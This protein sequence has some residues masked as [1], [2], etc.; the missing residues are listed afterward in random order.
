MSE[1]IIPEVNVEANVPS[2][3]PEPAE[4][5]PVV[6]AAAVN[7]QE[8]GIPELV[9][10]FE[11][12]AKSEDRMQR[13]KEADAIKSAFYKKLIKA[14]SEAGIDPESAEENPFT[15]IEEAFK[16]YY[17]AFKK[18]KAEY[19]KA[20]E[21]ER[22]RNLALKQAVIEDLKQL[23]EK[24][25]D[26]KVTFPEFRSIQDRWKAVGPVPVQNFRNLNETYQL[27]VEQF[28][29]M[30]NIN[31]ELRDLDFKK[32]LEAKTAFCEEAEALAQR[33]DVVEAFRE[34]QKLH[35]QW[36]DYGPVEKQYRESIWE[37]FKAATAVINRNYQAHFEGLKEQQEANL[38][39]KTALCEKAEAIAAAE[40]ANANEWNAATKTLEEIQKEW[41]GIGF[42]SKKDNQKIYDRF[43]AACDAFFARKKEF[44]AGF[45]E[46]INENLARK[47]AICEQAEALKDSTDWKATADTLIDLQKQWKEI[48]AVPR[49]KSDALWKRFRAACDSFFE[50]RDKQP[51]DAND[52]YGN[53]KAKQRLIAEIN[54][55]E[56][57]GDAEADAEAGSKFSES[58]QAI[59]FVPFK[60]KDRI[61]QAYREAMAKFNA[62]R[63]ASRRQRPERTPMT[64]KE[65]LVKK[66]N[67][68]EQDIVTYENNLGFFARSKNA[69]PLIR[70]MEERIAKAKEELR[71]LEA[72]IR[73]ME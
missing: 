11:Q 24:Q 72:E 34:L 61:A 62:G 33:S 19:N 40:M 9:A 57:S 41:R 23:L 46:S 56:L 31:R 22:E 25:E 43:R 8:M 17:N 47:L 32:N 73:S 66:Y 42:A 7:Y 5:A 15:G 35:E 58:W 49:Q 70:Q 52:Y 68:L 45:K 64:E 37:R 59:G 2:D 13:A 60:E 50:A 48:G 20:Q 44:Y 4:M 36:K 67:Q 27:Y 55:Y 65:R 30:V 16:A 39:A 54:A 28:Y 6:E 71:S 63:G 51:K 3:V 21:A 10:A 26:V 53:L 1:E 12:L 29:D 38:V 18:E 69:E 14:K